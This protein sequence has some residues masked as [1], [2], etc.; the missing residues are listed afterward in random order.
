MGGLDDVGLPFGDLLAGLLGDDLA[1]F[2]GPLFEF[3]VDIPE[4]LGAVDVGKRLPVLRGGL[5]GGDGGLDVL[6]RAPVDLDQ[7]FPGGRVLRDERLVAGAGRPLA[8][9]VVLVWFGGQLFAND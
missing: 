6:W 1:E 8:A 5:G 9:D 2:V 7:G 4:V 3:V